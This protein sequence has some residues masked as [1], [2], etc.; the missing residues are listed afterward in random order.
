MIGFFLWIWL[1]H[2][3]GPLGTVLKINVYTCGG[4]QDHGILHVLS[5]TSIKGIIISKQEGS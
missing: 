1:I 4:E 2:H 5:A 3:F